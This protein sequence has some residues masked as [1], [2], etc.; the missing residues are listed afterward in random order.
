MS[1]S[2]SIYALKHVNLNNEPLFT[3]ISYTWR[4][5][6]QLEQ[7]RIDGKVYEVRANVAQILRCLVKPEQPRTVWIDS[8]CIDQAN[9]EERNHQV[10][11][12][13]DIFANANY[14]ISWLSPDNGLLADKLRL[15]SDITH[16]R[17]SP[18][19]S[20]GKLQALLHHF[21]NHRYWTRRWIVQEVILAHY[22]I[23][24]T[25]REHDGQA[26]ELRMSIL[27]EFHTRVQEM[28]ALGLRRFDFSSSL[29]ID[30]AT[31][32]LEE[33]P[34]GATLRSLLLTYRDTKCSEVR[35]RVFGLVGLS[36]MASTNFSVNYATDSVSLL[37]SVVLFAIEHENLSRTDIVGFMHLL[38]TELNLSWTDLRQATASLHENAFDPSQLGRVSL[39]YRGRIQS[40]SIPTSEE[41]YIHRCRDN[42][43]SLK[44][45]QPI[46][47]KYDTVTQLLDFEGSIAFVESTDPASKNRWPVS[48]QDLCPI[49]F[50]STRLEAKKR[51]ADV[52]LATCRVQSGDEI[53]QFPDTPVALIARTEADAFRLWGRAFL[54]KTSTN[55]EKADYYERRDWLE[56]VDKGSHLAKAG[57]I[58]WNVRTFKVNFVTLL[59]ILKWVD[60]DP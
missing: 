35:D 41:A 40:R 1:N 21:F 31:S 4:S 12:M 29:A 24:M 8:I 23:M 60:Y 10:Q 32:R 54:L 36:R 14:V 45:L 48:G 34:E 56:V 7:I 26:E 30:L 9:L 33:A 55:I 6:D 11:L 22:I 51:P 47:L 5:E 46:T 49:N 13:C 15:I 17:T 53:W 2:T 19:Q 58:G 18:A 39:I 59:N 38:R 42:A 50:H 3:A 16:D 37:F 43:P 57:S 52:G 25:P 27:P 20:H 44:R 28:R